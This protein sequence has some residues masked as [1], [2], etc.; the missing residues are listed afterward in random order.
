MEIGIMV[1]D[2][3]GP[4]AAAD[5]AAQA[6]AADGLSTVWSAQALGWDALTA[7]TVAG[8]AQPAVRLG[9]AVVP[10]RQRHPLILAAQALSVQAATGNRLTLGIGAGIG[11][12]VGGMFG[13]R[14]DRPVAYLRE[15]LSVLRPLLA[16]TPVEHRGE[17]LTAVGAVQVPGAEPPPVLLA[18]LGPAMRQ[19][20]REAADGIITWM[21]GPRVLETLVARSRP[22]SP[23]SRVVAEP[24]GAGQLVTRPSGV[25]GG[26]QDVAGF[27]RAAPGGRDPA[28]HP[29]IASSG[30][31]AA[32]L[33]GVAGGWRVV[34]G[35]PVCVTADRDVRRRIASHY[36][37]AGEVP[38]YRAVLSREG[39]SDAGEVA[40]AGDEEAVA[41][42][43]TRLTEVGVGEFMAAPFGSAEEQARTA[44]FLRSL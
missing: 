19:L 23:R 4:A 13:L 12:M 35:L 30:R 6:R 27:P 1:G 14:T 20:A 44:E 3:R 9:T 24:P 34:A 16:G 29:D 41:R 2:V 38:E 8:A 22:A 36:A 39:A 7:L 26:G 15:Y 37:M 25:V 17:M 42:Q 11:A 43:L 10:V 31:Y 5:L 21:A 33:P 18:A 28:G 32:R 40:I